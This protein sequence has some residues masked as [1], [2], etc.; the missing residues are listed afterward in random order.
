M[1]ILVSNRCVKDDVVYLEEID[2]I[3]TNA[4]L[5]NN[6]VVDELKKLKNVSKNRPGAGSPATILLAD[7]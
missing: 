6:F 7:V 2:S 1:L 4:C 5:L 3:N